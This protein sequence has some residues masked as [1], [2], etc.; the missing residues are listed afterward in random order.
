MFPAAF[1]FISWLIFGYFSP[2]YGVVSAVW[3]TVFT[4]YWK[5]Q[6]T[7]LAVRWGV[8]G[9]SKIDTRHKD[10]APEKTITDPVTGE[11]MGFFHL[12][13]LQWPT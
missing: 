9:V 8:R 3:C 5:H 4:E 12:R 10:F 13:S 6:E 7:D 2:I 1:G 11:K